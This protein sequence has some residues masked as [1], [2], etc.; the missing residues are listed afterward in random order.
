MSDILL[1]TWRDLSLSV[2]WPGLEI[3]YII[4]V[5][6]TTPRSRCTVIPNKAMCYNIIISQH[7]FIIWT[8]LAICFHPVLPCLRLF[9]QLL[10]CLW[11]LDV[12]NFAREGGGCR[13][14][15][16]LSAQ[17]HTF[18]SFEYWHSCYHAEMIRFQGV[19]NIS[20]HTYLHP[21]KKAHVE[22]HITCLSF[23]FRCH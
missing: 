21:H 12:A 19:V 23:L 6:T 22:T 14:P 16:G 18:G 3:Q 5:S 4:D 7:L 11:S 8:T 15:M 1:L 2:S 20:A 10:R 9:A 13:A 17:D